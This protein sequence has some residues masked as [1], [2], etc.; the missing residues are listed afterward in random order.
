MQKNR[1]LRLLRDQAWRTSHQLRLILLALACVLSWMTT[2]SDAQTTAGGNFYV[3]PIGDDS[4]SGSLSTPWKTITHAVLS[5]HPGDTIFLRGGTYQETEIWI[6]DSR[7]GS[8]GNFKTIQ[9]YNGEQPI[10]QNQKGISL[11]ASWIRIQ[12]IQFQGV[13]V[14]SNTLDGTVPDNVQIVG[15]SFYGATPGAAIDVVGDNLLINRNWIAMKS[16]PSQADSGI[17]LRYGQNNVISGNY[18]SGTTGPGLYI[19]DESL[20]VYP[21]G[22][23]QSGYNNVVIAGNIIKGSVMSSGLVLS[24]DGNFAVQNITINNNVSSGNH[25]NGLDIETGL[26]V[27]IFNNTIYG[28][29]AD[30]ILV[31][32]PASSQMVGVQIE[33]NILD[34][35]C[36]KKCSTHRHVEVTNPGLFGLVVMDN[37][38]WPQSIGS[39]NAVDSRPLF[40]DPLFTNAA[41]G[42]FTLQV[43]SPAIDAGVLVSLPFIGSAPDLGAFESNA[44]TPPVNQPLPD[45]SNQTITKSSTTNGSNQAIKANDKKSFPTVSAGPDQ[46]IT[47]PSAATL[48]GSVTVVPAGTPTKITWSMSSG[49]GTVTFANASAP[50]TT[51]TFSTAG[52]YVLTL[53]ATAAGLTSRSQVTI[54]VNPAVPPTVSAGPN[55]TIT[56]PSTATLAGSVTVVPGGTNATT[57]WSMSSGPGTVTFANANAASTTA[58]FSTAGSYVLTLTATAA[59]LTSRSQ[60]TIT[61]NP[62]VLPTVSAGLN[63]TITLPSAATLAGSVTSGTNATTTW[64]MSSGPGTVTFANANSPSTT[65]TFS[66]AGSYVLTLTATAAGLTSK[67]QVTITVNPGALPTVSAG[68]NQTIT[69]PSTATLA[70]SV[71]VVPAGTPV[72]ITW[73]VSSGPGTVTFANA[74]A[75]STTA[76]FSTA[77]SYVLTL[78][79]TAAGLTSRSFV[80]I[81]VNALTA[82]LGWDAISDPNLAGYNLYRSNQPGVFT[83]VPLNGSTLLTVPAFTDSTV[84]SGN[85]YYY[86]VRAVSTSGMQ[87][88]NS[89]VIQV[90]R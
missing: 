67:S 66:T 36:T 15:N 83:S 41:G 35:P 65:A 56:L 24:T 79:A 42:D 28:N 69:L 1:E 7:G 68:P 85:T 2:V 90:T 74:N 46:I 54:T 45:G 53:T 75:P 86:T 5:T 3:S 31:A 49:P 57:T 44:P 17:T 14:N 12:G 52:S 87:S 18:I 22:A 10:L 88:P 77:G 47:L 39:T 11:S 60:V 40:A 62:A 29:D 55:Q 72:T 80:T 20:S 32:Y 30:G 21:A 51:A 71:T 73:S 43:G 25:A 26:G 4:N 33:N 8:P 9:N 27:K 48:A 58:T 84:Q 59:G 38:Y 82:K 78:T 37:L 34:D 50:S 16:Q 70:G 76:T 89:N 61:V 19:H 6:R 63:Q 13:G 64:S 23:A 81:T